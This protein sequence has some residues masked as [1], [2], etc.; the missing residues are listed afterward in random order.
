M[1]FALGFLLLWLGFAP[2]AVA[3]SGAPPAYKDDRSDAG[4]LVRSLYNAVNRHEY[5]RAWSYFGNPPTKSFAA[6]VNGY[7]DTE[8]VDVYTGRV[9]SEGAAGSTYFQVPVAIRAT[10][11]KREAK[12]FAGCFTAKAVNPQIQEPPFQA[13]LIEKGSLKPKD[14]TL[15]STAAPEWCSDQ[16]PSKESAEEALERVIA[17][18]SDGRGRACDTVQNEGAKTP[19][20][21]ELRFRHASAGASGP[22]ELNRLYEFA[23]DSAAYN[24][25]TV[26]YLMDSSGAVSELAFS[27]PQLDIS[28]EEAD[29]KKLKAMTVVGFTSTDNLQNSS[30][31]GTNN[32]ISS[33]NKWRG[34]ADASSNGTWVFKEGKFVLISYEAD[35]TYDGEINPVTVIVDGRVK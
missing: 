1:R 22:E 31:D 11:S 23:C 3:E 24:F 12:V 20:V 13:L 25:S 17:L 29:H 4:A 33:F 19:E 7:G 5:A 18:F 9:T 30:F 10:N 16:E 35:P 21:Y 2:A 27:E 34:I 15:L 14:E 28:Y 32:S 26:Y 8:R 6:F